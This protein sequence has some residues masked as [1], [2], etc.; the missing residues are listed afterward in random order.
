MMNYAYEKTKTNVKT[1]TIKTHDIRTDNSIIICSW[2]YIWKQCAFRDL[3]LKQKN[4][5]WFDLQLYKNYTKINVN[6]ENH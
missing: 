2:R 3:L 6:Q 1:H 4:K 5:I